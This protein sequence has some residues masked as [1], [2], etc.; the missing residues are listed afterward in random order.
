MEAPN[1]YEEDHI[2]EC[3]RNN[4]DVS[5]S[6]NS[7]TNAAWTTALGDTVHIEPGDTVSM[8]AGYVNARGC[9]T[10]GRTIELK[11]ETLGKT[12]ELIYSDISTATP[13]N[14]LQGYAYADNTQTTEQILM[15]DNEAT[16]GVSY[17]K[18]ADGHH[19]YFGPRRFMINATDGGHFQTNYPAPCWFIPD[20]PLGW[21]WDNPG[22]PLQWTNA[23]SVPG[24]TIVFNHPTEN[25]TGRP[26]FEVRHG[27]FRDTYDPTDWSRTGMELMR[28]F[29]FHDYREYPQLWI[30][31]VI[32]TAIPQMNLW[33]PKNDNAKFTMFVRRKATIY[34]NDELVNIAYC[35]DGHVDIS[36][37]ST[38]LQGDTVDDQTAGPMYSRYIEKKTISIPAGFN[39]GEFIA[40]EI[41]RQLSQ[42][43]KETTFT[44]EDYK[45]GSDTVYPTGYAN[46]C[47]SECYKPFNVSGAY[48]VTK[49]QYDTYK[50]GLPMADGAAPVRG[51]NWSDWFSQYQ[52]VGI[53][54]P[55]LYETGYYVNRLADSKLTG[56]LGSYVHDDVTSPN[57]PIITNI[58]YT[59]SNLKDLKAF[60]DAQAKYPEIWDDI[61]KS[62][63]D[64]TA[65]TKITNTRWFHMN[66]YSNYMVTEGTHTPLSEAEAL[67]TPLGSDGLREQNDPSR[68]PDPP[69]VPLSPN[70][71]RGSYLFFTHYDESQK[72]TF[73]PLPTDPNAVAEG[74]FMNPDSE[75][76]SYGCFGAYREQP[77]VPGAYVNYLV[78]LYPNKAPEKLAD[79]LFNPDYPDTAAANTIEKYRKI[80]YDLHFNAPTT[81]AM[82]PMNGEIDHPY[83]AN[84]AGLEMPSIRGNYNAGF[85]KNQLPDIPTMFQ[86]V[87]SLPIPNLEAISSSNMRN[88]STGPASGPS[89]TTTIIQFLNQVYMGASSPKLTY[90]GNH[91]SWSYL[92]TPA[93][94]GNTSLAGLQSRF[95]ENTNASQ[96]CYKINPTEQYN[97]FT[98]ERAPYDRIILAHQS[99]HEVAVNPEQAFMP[100]KATVGGDQST[101]ANGEVVPDA[102]V[103]SSI[104]RNLIPYEVYDSKTGI[105]IE[106]WGYDEDTW[107]DGLWGILGYTYEQF[108]STTNS[109]LNRITKNNVNSLS[110]LT[111]NSQVVVSDAKVRMMNPQKKPTYT[112]GIS[113]PWNIMGTQAQGDESAVFSCLSYPEIIQNTHS[114]SIKALQLPK[115]SISGY[116]GVRSNIMNAIGFR[117]ERATLPILGIVNKETAIGD[118]FFGSESSI[119]F[120]CNKKTTISS[121]DIRITD[122]D[123]T[124]ADISPDST[125]LIKISKQRSVNYDILSQ[126]LAEESGK[127]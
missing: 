10:Q 18:N 26:L 13:A 64:Y 120:T 111:T 82:I 80:G 123:G 6:D 50:A 25:D 56:S 60:L 68:S 23:S 99:G 113:H 53:K 38:V 63:N 115:S 11:G 51:N 3:N 16:I 4:A 27:N 32:K 9:G 89:G 39:S 69:A 126:I 52:F 96:E 97:D 20:V 36:P 28:N 37:A 84:S 117:G 100:F 19:Y 72:D 66:K 1:V 41:T 45:E 81:V 125:I 110:V 29:V 91:F 87:K 48:M 108:H 47:E 79:H 17:Y 78:V 44:Y 93:Q 15:K 67:G 71:N 77:L 7:D 106:D 92:H 58:Q 5:G 46:S 76:Y 74:T 59:E 30:Y 65:L 2:I 86:P 21:N 94:I 42:I 101:L 118:Y 35:P 49:A 98:P 122:P 55:E 95:L 61:N 103:P 33:K 62:F 109:R 12:K 43:K 75:K 102:I 57:D 104:N 127:K 40:D 124:N 121:V 105:F 54:R 119:A 73:Y 90:D 8:Y 22:V 116:Y 85:S 34:D 107:N 88:P 24:G 114:L 112:L 70:L 31:D 14:N 83:Y